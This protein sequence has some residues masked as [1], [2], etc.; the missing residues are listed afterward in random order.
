MKK[1]NKKT[2]VVFYVGILLLFLFMVSLNLTGGL[3]AR[4]TTVYESGDGARVAVFKA[5]FKLEDGELSDVEEVDI[6]FAFGDQTEYRL[7]VSNQSEV[8]VNYRVIAENVTNNLPLNITVTELS[9][10]AYDEMLDAD[11]TKELVLTI[12][13]NGT[14]ISPDHS[15][16]VDL[17][18]LT[19]VAEQV[20]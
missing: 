1:S 6:T 8:S 3:Y 9:G 17:I 15:G 20:D 16:K 18:K 7:Q 5:D 13:W 19:I 2:P 10:A 11:T 4:Y 14:E 12:D